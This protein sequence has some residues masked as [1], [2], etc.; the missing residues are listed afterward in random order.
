MAAKHTYEATS[1]AMAGGTHHQ[2][3]CPKMVLKPESSELFDDS[4]HDRDGHERETHHDP[5]HRPRPPHE[6]AER[7]RRAG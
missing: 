4:T 6:A 1:T 2:S 3:K 5:D 7:S